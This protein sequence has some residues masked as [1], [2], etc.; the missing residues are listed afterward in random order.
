[1]RQASDRVQIGGIPELVKDKIR[2]L[3][4]EPGNADE[5]ASSIKYLLD[6]PELK[7]D[8]G[9]NAKKFLQV[10]MNSERHYVQLMNVYKKVLGAYRR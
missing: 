8:M 6:N 10:E 3:I 7:K 1:L 5:L 4:F 2:G 9:L